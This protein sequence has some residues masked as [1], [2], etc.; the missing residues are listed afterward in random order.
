MEC[1]KCQSDNP[2]DSHYCRICGTSFELTAK[3]STSGVQPGYG[4]HR[5]LIP[6]TSFAGRYEI[7]EEL[8]RG[9]MGIVY[10]AEDIKLKRHVALKFLPWELTRNPEAKERFVHEAQAASSLDHA[11][12]CTVHEIDETDDG[13]MYISMGCY[14]GETLKTKIGR[15]PVNVEETSNIGIQ[16]A[17]GLSEAHEKG[18]V[19]RDIKPSNIMVTDRGEAKIMDFGLAKLAGQTRLTKAGTTLGTIAYM[20]PEQARGQDV[21]HRADIWSLGAILYEMVTGMLPFKGEYDQ[22]VIYSILNEEAGPVSESGVSVPEEIE[23]II[24]T[25][26][27][28]NPDARYQSARE[29]EMALRRFRGEPGLEGVALGQGA[30]P[31]RYT[32]S[33]L[34]RIG[35]PVAIAVIAASLLMVP[36]PVRRAFRMSVGPEDAARDLRVAV[37]PCNL[38]GG[39]PEDRALCD[40]MTKVLTDKLVS[41]EHQHVGFRVLARTDV[42]GLRTASPAD[43]WK[44]LGANVSITGSLR[45]SGRGFEL[46]LVRNDIDTEVQAGVDTEILRQHSTPAIAEPIANLS[47]WQDSIIAYVADLLE[48]NLSP[49]DL[50]RLA[51]GGTVVPEAYLAYLRGL[52]LMFPYEGG[53]DVDASMG[54]FRRAVELDPSYALAHTELGNAYYRKLYSTNDEQWIEPANTSCEH[55]I[56]NEGAMARAHTVLGYVDRWTGDYESAIKHFQDAIAVDSTDYRAYDGMAYTYELLG[57]LDSAEILLKRAIEIRPLVSNLHHELGDFYYARA[58][59]EDAIEPFRKMIALKPYSPLGYNMLGVSCFQLERMD[60]AKE[61]L[62]RSIALGP[63]YTACANLGTIYFAETRYADAA[64]MYEE[65]LDILD[66]QYRVWGNLAESYYWC[67]GE[68]DKAFSNFEHAVELGKAALLE[69]SSSPVILSDLASYHVRLGDQPTA[70]E[71]LD[72]VTGLGPSEP[73]VLFRIAETYEGLGDQEIAL[74]WLEA[75]FEQGASSIKVDRFPGLRRLRSDPRYQEL[76]DRVG[77]GKPKES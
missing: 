57:D 5:T 64:T 18:I 70:R 60:D 1:P 68:R 45:K 40:G 22:A 16:V 23:T 43:A 47:T 39:A 20:S 52:G 14:D 35:I 6:G 25:C 53:R 55:A 4:P 27:Q 50:S 42:R 28:K 9:G 72:E 76:L 32:P 8:G 56:L 41:L 74:R 54:L 36:G 11:A 59:Y 13:Q 71:L 17:R 2:D 33:R 24:A 26:L 30:R 73:L 31:R 15:G 48:I 29:L 49:D 62:E 34:L 67:P 37:L 7:L 38:A 19:H 44:Y 46:V 21:D 10:K 12:I 66:T 3:T 58:R 51:A 75:A 63:T 65:A 69:D 77:H 61:A